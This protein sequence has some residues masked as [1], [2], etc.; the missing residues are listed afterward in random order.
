MNCLLFQPIYY[1]LFLF[2][3][4]G[5]VDRLQDVEQAR[6][7][8][9]TIQPPFI[10]LVQKV[11]GNAAAAFRGI[12]KQTSVSG[13]H[14]VSS[15]D[16]HVAH[17]NSLGDNLVAA[18]D[19]ID[20]KLENFGLKNLNAGG[21][22]GLVDSL[23]ASYGNTAIGNPAVGAPLGIPGANLAVPSESIPQLAANIALIQAP[24]EHLLEGAGGVRGGFTSS[25]GNIFASSAI[26][27]FLEKYPPS[28][29]HADS[30]SVVTGNLGGSLGLGGIGGI[31]GGNA[32]VLNETTK[33]SRLPDSISSTTG[34]RL[35]NVFRQ[36]KNS[37]Y[38]TTRH[39]RPAKRTRLP[40][41]SKTLDGLR[42]A[43]PLTTRF[44]E[45]TKLSRLPNSMPSSTSKRNILRK[46]K[47]LMQNITEH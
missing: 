9:S 44:S 7:S 24:G 23:A 36:V 15:L 45:N 16:Q 38:E 3:M 5:A 27:N 12:A 8:A 2:K 35:E 20:N 18:G 10:K 14:L 43:I 42:Q 13:N 25:S 29:G 40:P 31:D 32:L 21:V 6:Q 11:L 30:N 33:R 26:D 22:S 19:T 39:D 47:H 4:L 1:K 34:K 17:A 46:A 41:T 28:F 37:F